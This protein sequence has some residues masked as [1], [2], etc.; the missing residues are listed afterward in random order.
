M[1][2]R[3]RERVLFRGFKKSERKPFNLPMNLLFDAQSRSSAGVKLALEKP[4]NNYFEVGHRGKG[5]HFVNPS[6]LIRSTQTSRDKHFKRRKM[7]SYGH[8]WGQK[9]LEQLENGKE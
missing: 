2:T 6:L 1:E 5:I 8:H 7:K 3:W 4:K 9:V